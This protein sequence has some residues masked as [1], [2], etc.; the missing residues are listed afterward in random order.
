MRRTIL[1]KV[2]MILYFCEIAPG[3]EGPKDPTQLIAA[4]LQSELQFRGID[5]FTRSTGDS[6]KGRTKHALPPVSKLLLP[7]LRPADKAIALPQH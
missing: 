1:S 5:Q 3:S 4:A 7:N 6:I 2:L